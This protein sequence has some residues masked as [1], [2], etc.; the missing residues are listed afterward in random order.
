MSEEAL[1][2]LVVDCETTG[3][4]PLEVI[5]L[6]IIPVFFYGRSLFEGSGIVNRS[7][8]PNGKITFGA[9]A[10]HHI[11]DSD[12]IGCSPSSEAKLPDGCKYMIGHNVD[13]DWQALGSPN[14]KRICTLALSRKLWPELDCHKLGAVAYRVFGSAA[15][16]M[17]VNAHS[18]LSDAR[19]TVNVLSKILERTGFETWEG[20][21]NLSELA[22]VPTHFTFGKHKGMLIKD[23]PSDYKAWLLRQ[24]DVDPY[25]RKALCS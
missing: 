12:L 7:F 15:K 10:T 14:V 3:G 20:V 9:M 22:R 18:A 13:Y 6:G 21:W 2:A 25:L 8:R 5:E 19:V 11:C 23:A 4:E 16:D 24:D 17:L 1:E